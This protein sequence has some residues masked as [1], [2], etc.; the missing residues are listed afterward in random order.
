MTAEVVFTPLVEV[1][2]STYAKDVSLGSGDE[3]IVCC[4]R[5]IVK[6]RFQ[7]TNSQ[8]LVP[9]VFEGRG[10]IPPP[11]TLVFFCGGRF[12]KYVSGVHASDVPQT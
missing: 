7:K 8:P 9:V 4:L 11:A 3:N 12:V 5:W 6:V 2:A 1:G 10:E